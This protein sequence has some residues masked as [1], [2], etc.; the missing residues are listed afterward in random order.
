L[1]GAVDGW[2]VGVGGAAP[3]TAVGGSGNV[4]LFSGRKHDGYGSIVVA[5]HLQ[6]GPPHVAAGGVRCEVAALR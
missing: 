1:R 3:K 2:E 6:S 4:P 5:V